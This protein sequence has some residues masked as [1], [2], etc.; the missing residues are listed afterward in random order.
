LKSPVHTRRLPDAA[1][2]KEVEVLR[3]MIEGSAEPPCFLRVPA[4]AIH[5]S[6]QS[7]P[8]LAPIV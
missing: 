7:T 6:G 2:V 8:T 5:T 1:G 4:S 3:E